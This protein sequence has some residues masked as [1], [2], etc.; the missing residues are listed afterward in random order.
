ML[1]P[2]EFRKFH[3]MVTDYAKRNITPWASTAKCSFKQSTEPHR[4]RWN[5]KRKQLWN[6]VVREVQNECSI[7][8]QDI[9]IHCIEHTYICSSIVHCISGCAPIH[10]QRLSCGECLWVWCF[11]TGAH[12]FCVCF[13]VCESTPLGNRLTNSGWY[14]RQRIFFVLLMN[15]YS[16]KVH[17]LLFM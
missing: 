15:L 1:P 8:A 13:S 16:L 2:L 4:N 6:I 3:H 9:W 14:Q 10:T 12:R 7:L 17:R 5:H 11:S